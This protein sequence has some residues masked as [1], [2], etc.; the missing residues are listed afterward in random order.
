MPKKSEFLRVKQICARLNISRSTWLLW[1]KKKKAPA[2]I[3]FGERVIVWLAD[4]V[5][6][7]IKNRFEKSGKK[8]GTL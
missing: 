6:E 7:F 1:V 4:E 2:G 5:E 8:G 3:R